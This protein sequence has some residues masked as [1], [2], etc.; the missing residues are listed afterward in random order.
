VGPSDVVILVPVLRRPHRVHPL[1]E[2]LAA[3]TPEP[4]RVLFLC[5]PDDE[6]EIEAVRSSGA[7][8][9]ICKP[10]MPGDYA[11]KINHGYHHSTEPLIFLGADDLKFHPDWL[12]NA[13]ARLTETIHVVGTNDLGNKRVMAG[14]HST[15]TLLTRV[16]A[17]KH[18]TIDQRETILHEGYEHCFTDDEFIHTARARQMFAFAPDSIVEHLHPNWNKAE[19]DDVYSIADQSLQKGR[20]LFNRRR[21][22]WVRR[23]PYARRIGR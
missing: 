8:Y 23:Y 18:G 7:D 20:R 4:H 21:Q 12:P 2:S 14:I 1:L 5:S 22:L 11:R 17:D 16:Y 9:L 6:A 19:W 10:W 3:N 15:H 13:L